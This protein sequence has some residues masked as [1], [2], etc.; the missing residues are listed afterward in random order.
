MTTPALLLLEELSQRAGLDAIP[1]ARDA[2]TAIIFG[3]VLVGLD[4]PKD[5]T[6]SLLATIKPPLGREAD[7]LTEAVAHNEQQANGGGPSVGYDE[8][9]GFLTV[10]EDIDVLGLHYPEFEARLLAFVSLC[11]RLANPAPPD[12]DDAQP[13]P[14]YAIYG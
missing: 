9:E 3:E 5:A 4:I 10:S 12:D 8:D 14:A 13:P 1:F 2:Y 11:E 7:V 6:L